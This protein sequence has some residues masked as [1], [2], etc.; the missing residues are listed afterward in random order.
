MN[1]PLGR[2]YV[3]AE[4]AQDAAEA[5]CEQ[6]IGYCGLWVVIDEAHITTLAVHPQRRGQHLGELLFSH[7]LDRL[8]GQVIHVVTLEVRASNTGAQALYQKYGFEVMGVRPRYYQDTHEDALIMSLNAFLGEENRKRYAE[9]KQAL[10][11]K[12]NGALPQGFGLP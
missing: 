4:A 6:I 1:N 7:C 3:F 5:P 11:Q 12:F 8:M 9:L 10:M 2:Y